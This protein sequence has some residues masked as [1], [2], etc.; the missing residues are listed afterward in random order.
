MFHSL[1]ALIRCNSSRLGFHFHVSPHLTAAADEAQQEAMLMHSTSAAETRLPCSA[2][3][4]QLCGR[5]DVALVPLAGQ[6]AAEPLLCCLNSFDDA[7]HVLALIEG[8]AARQVSSRAYAVV[9]QPCSGKKGQLI[10]EEM[11]TCP[12]NSTTKACH[13]LRIGKILMEDAVYMPR[14]ADPGSLVYFCWLSLQNKETLAGPPVPQTVLRS[15]HFRHN[16][17]SP[18][19]A[20][21]T[22]GCKVTAGS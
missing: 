20:R 11:C 13:W 10:S 4:F 15:V 6:R 19:P 9:R 22:G 2:V 7:L 14:T 17:R 16:S 8:C 5:S 1:N 18:P 12:N 21:R 3:I